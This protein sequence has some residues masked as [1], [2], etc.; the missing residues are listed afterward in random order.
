MQAIEEAKA[1]EELEK[2]AM[3]VEKAAMDELEG[4]A[5]T[6]ESGVP[7]EQETY[8]ED[9]EDVVPEETVEMGTAV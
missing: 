1:D 8:L 7:L 5:A 3:E 6:E 2:Q 4:G 9:D